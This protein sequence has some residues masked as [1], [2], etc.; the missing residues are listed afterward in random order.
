MLLKQIKLVKKNNLQKGN[1]NVIVFYDKFKALW[2]Q[3]VELENCV[4]CNVCTPKNNV[5]LEKDK[6]YQFLLGLNEDIKTPRG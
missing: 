2:D 4:F 6:I 3:K 5:K 1:D